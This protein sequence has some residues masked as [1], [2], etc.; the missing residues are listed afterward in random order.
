MQYRM[1][2]PT[3]VAAENK[4]KIQA[5]RPTEKPAIHTNAEL[6]IIQSKNIVM[7]VVAASHLE[8]MS[9]VKLKL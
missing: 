2:H 5:V 4:L 8:K 9:L 1:K 6:H 3:A 7:Q